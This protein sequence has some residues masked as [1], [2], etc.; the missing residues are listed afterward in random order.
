MDTSSPAV[1][2]NGELLKMYVGRRVRTVLNVAK[3]EGGV[4]SGKCTDGQQ[5]TVK[6]GDATSFPVSHFVEVIGIADSNQSIRVEIC[7]DF[8][9]QFGTSISFLYFDMVQFF[10]FG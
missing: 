9:E 7:T 8:G 4:T 1:F 2:V 5:L 3:N 10:H 6:G